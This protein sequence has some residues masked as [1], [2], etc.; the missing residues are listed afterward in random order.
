MLSITSDEQEASHIQDSQDC[1]WITVITLNIKS[2]TD[3]LKVLVLLF[4]MSDY[5]AS[6]LPVH[7]DDEF[8]E[9]NV[10]EYLE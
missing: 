2:A 5:F 1:H 7:H 9:Q 6:L 10:V 3:F 4:T 8:S